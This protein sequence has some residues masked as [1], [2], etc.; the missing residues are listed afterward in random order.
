MITPGEGGG[1]KP[2]QIITPDQARTKPPQP[3]DTLTVVEKYNT[4]EVDVGPKQE[5]GNLNTADGSSE[6]TETIIKPG[7]GEQIEDENQPAQTQEELEKVARDKKR[8]ELKQ[9]TPEQ[10][11]DHF[12]TL[13]SEFSENIASAPSY[14]LAKEELIK[15]LREQGMTEVR[16]NGEVSRMDRLFDELRDGAEETID[17]MKREGTITPEQAQEKKSKIKE[18]FEMGLVAAGDWVKEGIKSSDSKTIF[19][20]FLVF[21]AEGRFGGS[22]LSDLESMKGTEADDYLLN[23]VRK[24]PVYLTAAIEKAFGS[25]G[26]YEDISRFEPNKIGNDMDKLAALVSY[27]NSKAKQSEENWNSLSK[28]MVEFLDPSG[29][30][31]YQLSEKTKLIFDKLDSADS[32]RSFLG[33]ETSETSDEAKENKGNDQQQVDSTS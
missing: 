3:G 23:E 5:E 10:R 2:P 9:L 30:K 8:Q 20:L 33:I 31:G 25:S 17:E 19:D 11:E 15:E 4:H 14:A 26:L 22:S 13:L 16:I 12:Q 24:N 32:L 18:Y 21:G 7:E 27:F 28:G 1:E 6:D 29:Q